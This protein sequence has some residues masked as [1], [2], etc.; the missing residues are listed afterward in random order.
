MNWFLK[1]KN[2]FLLIVFLL[3]NW[4]ILRPILRSDTF[5]LPHDST[6]LVRLHQFDK[7]VSLGQFPPRLAPDMAYGY[8]YPIFKYY[9]PLFTLLSWLVF[10]LIGDYALSVTLV[11]FLANL[12]GSWGMFLLGKRLYGFW[13]GLVSSA[14]FI[15]LPFRALDIYVRGA[16]AEILAINHLPFW[17]YFFILLSAKKFNKKALVGFILISAGLILSHNLYLLVLACFLPLWLIYFFSSGGFSW[18]KKILIL[19]GAAFLVL[20]ITAWFWLP[21]VIGLKDVG[22][23]EQAGKT[24]FLDHFVYP[25]QLWNW[26][27]G[28]A[29]SAPGLA[30]GMSF[31]LGKAHILLALAGVILIFLN[32][33]SSRLLWLFLGVC[34]G[35][36]FLALPWSISFW[37]TMPLLSTIQF[38]WRFLGLSA[39]ILA[40]LSGGVVLIGKSFFF[41]RIRKLSV[42]TALLAV[43]LFSFFNFKYFAPQKIVLSAQKNLLD[44][45]VIYRSSQA[46]A[47][48]YPAAVI[49]RPE[50]KPDWPL[51]FS[52]QQTAQVVAETPFKI[53]FRL[54]DPGQINI[55]RFYFPGWQLFLENKPVSINPE[56]AIGR[57]QFEA[58]EKGEYRLSFVTTPWEKIAYV[59]TVLG[60]IILIIVTIF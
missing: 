16:F 53:I 29:G 3:L 18:K 56:P 8:G 38:P 30:D 48:Y 54:N 1:N 43:F 34:L 10:K 45:E 20:L 57:I 50:E 58:E 19:I 36:L 27:W 28:F 46:V 6:W 35:G 32:K 40:L 44:R 37:R 41:V 52:G 22:A 17:L 39:P 49:F 13:G 33:K 31:K 14:A 59:L 21:L 11:V 51:A 42:L 25:K 55:N 4:L 24:S 15:F 26:P 12:V 47:E 2:W 60:V 5:F 7:A 23:L 9:A